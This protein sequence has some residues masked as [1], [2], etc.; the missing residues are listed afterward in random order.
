MYL[1]SE[2]VLIMAPKLLAFDKIV[3]SKEFFA[4]M[5]HPKIHSPQSV[6]VFR[7]KLNRLLLFMGSPFVFEK[8]TPRGAGTQLKPFF[9]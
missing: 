3:K 8:L 9:S 4:P 2:S 1:T 5:L 6:H 7:L